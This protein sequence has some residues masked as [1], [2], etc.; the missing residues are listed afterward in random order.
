MNT[1]ELEKVKQRVERLGL[2]Y[3]IEILS[4]LVKGGVHI[5]ENK[6][7]IRLNLGF[8]YENHRGVFD[9][10]VRYV[11][12]AEEKESRLDTVEHEKQEISSTYFS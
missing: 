12:Y 1:I 3:Q 2:N 4:I 8:V 9:E 10:M 7:G 5:N 11:D 6:S